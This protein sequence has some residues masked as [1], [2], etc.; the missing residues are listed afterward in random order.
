MNWKKNYIKP[1]TLEKKSLLKWCMNNFEPLT[2][3][4]SVERSS[5]VLLAT[6]FA[7]IYLTSF[8]SSSSNSCCCW[9]HIA[10]RW[11][12]VNHATEIGDDMLDFFF[13]YFFFLFSTS[14]LYVCLHSSSSPGIPTII[15]NPLCLHYLNTSSAQREEEKPIVL[16]NVSDDKVLEMLLLI[17]LLLLLI[18]V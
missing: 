5:H 14:I 2:C 18:L 15:T 6:T 17:L 9:L 11:Y 12:P 3:F 4:S 1:W 16:E 10:A 8:N 13:M 7:Y